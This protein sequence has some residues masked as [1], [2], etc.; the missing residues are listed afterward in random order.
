MAGAG[1]HIGTRQ[2]VL[3]GLLD[4]YE[5]TGDPQSA[6]EIAQYVDMATQNV[7]T[8]MKSAWHAGRVKR[9]ECV[10]RLGMKVFGYE[11]TDS[12]YAWL[13]LIEQRQNDEP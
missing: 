11:P 13:Q 8:I 10:N 12:A 5:T 2:R 4:L 9:I 3:R 7:N 6:T 1:I